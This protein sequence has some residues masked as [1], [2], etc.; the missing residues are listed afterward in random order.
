MVILPTM[1][2][3][4]LLHE[5]FGGLGGIA[6]FNRD[7]LTAAAAAPAIEQ[8]VAL[9]RHVPSPTGSLPGKIA[10]VEGAAGGKA[11]FALAV[12]RRA[13][14]GGRFDV[15]ICGH[16]R[17]LWLG[18][19]AARLARAPLLLVV[20]G[21]DAWTPP[22]GAARR[23]VARVDAVLS[24]SQVTKDRFLA[25]AEI[26]PDRVHVVPP[27]FDPSRFQP[28]P[29]DPALVERYRLGGKPVI[30]TLARLAG[31][32]RY[33]GIDEVLD[34]LPALLRR[35]PG[36][37]YLIAGDGPDRGRLE[38]KARTL[39]LAAHVRFC[40]RIAE[41]EK[42]DHFRLAD[43]FV[44]PGRG[45]GFGIVYLEAMACGIPVLGSRLDG[46]RDALRGGR[47]GIL[48]DPTDAGEL[49]AGIDAALDRPKGVPE[50]LDEFRFDRF[51]D[52]L[53]DL[54]AS[55]APTRA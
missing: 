41:A 47:L 27:A 29:R 21:I 36:L 15:V 13:R 51:A 16:V 8:V 14:F 23:L 7:L 4:V 30:L 20:Y 9:P 25:W 49:V 33:K 18:Y 2:L 26:P 52:R 50:G 10:Y 34:S 54:L 45:E 19:L 24:V 32:E 43:A 48:V 17:M 5:A 53:G 40:G 3:L 42:A 46:S 31:S 55:V 35:R 28:G 38:E 6:Q 39:D 22:N 44:M 11:R 12:L 1:R 37:V